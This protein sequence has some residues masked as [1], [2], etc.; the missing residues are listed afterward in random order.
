MTSDSNRDPGK[1][2]RYRHRGPRRATGGSTVSQGE[3]ERLAGL[4]D[5]RATPE[6]EGRGSQRGRS[7]GATES[8]EATSPGRGDDARGRWLRE[9][10]PPHWD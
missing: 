2:K 10:R 1:Q 5:T 6:T 7:R 9:Q 4:G 8:T 3:P